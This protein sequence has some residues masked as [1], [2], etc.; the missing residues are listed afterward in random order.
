MNDVKN[1]CKIAPVQTEPI[2]FDKAASL[3]KA[4]QY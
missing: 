2:M 1:I 3:K 4:L